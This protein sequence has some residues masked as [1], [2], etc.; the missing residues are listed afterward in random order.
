MVLPASAR[1]HSHAAHR[2]GRRDEGA[3]ARRRPTGSR[4]HRRDAARRRS[5]H[6]RGSAGGH[7]DRCRH[8]AARRSGR[9]RTLLRSDAGQHA[10]PVDVG[11]EVHRRVCLRRSWRPRRRLDPEAPI[12]QYIP[13]I[14][15]S[16]YDGATV[17][18]LLDMRTGVAFSEAYEDPNAE[19]RVIERHMGWR[20][21]PRAGVS[22]CTPI[23]PRCPP[24]GPTAARSSTAR[25][26]PT[27]WAGCA[28]G[29]PA[30]GWPTWC[31]PLSGP[32]WALSTTPKS[33]AMRSDP[34]CTTV[35]Q[36][37]R[38]RPGPLRQAAARRRLGR[39]P[40]R[41][42]RKLAT[43]GPAHRR[44]HPRCVRRVRLRA[45]PAG[46]LVPQPVLVRPRTV[47]RHLAVPGHPRP[48]GL[49]RPRH[50]H[51]RGEALVVADASGPAHLLD[52]IRAFAAVGRHLA[53]FEPVGDAAAARPSGPSG[54]VEGQER[55]HG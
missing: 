21:W 27:Y 36:C 44:R 8:R 2:P 31:P 53:G 49:R 40:T 15:G 30:S 17:R 16:G 12:T 45:G 26:T 6:R 48:D 37:H 34:R 50:P 54:I 41:R 5:V 35:D 32:R 11:V 10:A 52:T 38:P 1:D 33:P 46:R 24:R 51:G 47:R 3:G 29:P 4:R 23:S 14:A 13:E 19:V 7:V 22:A 9:P 25:Q 55:G 18:H 42:A 28:S 43:A 20:P 39:A